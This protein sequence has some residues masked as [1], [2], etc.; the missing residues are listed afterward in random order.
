MSSSVFPIQNARAPRSVADPQ[1]FDLRDTRRVMPEESTTPGS[2]AR[3]T[4]RRALARPQCQAHG[5]ELPFPSI[6]T[7]ES[8]DSRN[9]AVVFP[10]EEVSVRGM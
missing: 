6:S 7:A 9:P 10:G 5:V 3:T 2:V 8:L 1:L 4:G